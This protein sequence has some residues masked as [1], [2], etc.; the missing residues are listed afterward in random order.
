MSHINVH[1]W[2]VMHCVY[3]SI[4]W[5]CWLVLEDIGVLICIIAMTFLVILMWPCNF[6]EHFFNFSVTFRCIFS[7]E[8]QMMQFKGKRLIRWKQNLHTTYTSTVCCVLS[9]H[10]RTVS[11]CIDKC[12][13]SK[14]T[15][16]LCT[17][18][19]TTKIIPRHNLSIK[20]AL[21]EPDTLDQVLY[22]ELVNCST[23]YA[24]HSDWFN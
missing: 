6:Y 24:V 23:Y 16:E 4:I 1:V 18:I 21:V 10:N 11:K 13:C 15:V 3:L 14:I 22:P 5:C 12:I 19:I 20:L 2:S 9:P 8:S 7:P 17:S